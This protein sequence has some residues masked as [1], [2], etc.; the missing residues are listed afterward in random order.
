VT[1]KLIPLIDGSCVYRTARKPW[2]CECETSGDPFRRTGKGE[3]CIHSECR[4][5]INPSD[6]YIEY[7]GESAAYE[8]GIRYCLPCGLAVWAER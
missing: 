3:P 7:L 2:K 5:E 1:I 8:S 6:R 4:G